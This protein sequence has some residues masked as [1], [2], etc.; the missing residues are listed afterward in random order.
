MKELVKKMVEHE[1]DGETSEDAAKA[2]LSVVLADI[3]ESPERYVK[4]CIECDG[5]GWFSKWT[6]HKGGEVTLEQ[7]QCEWC[8]GKGLVAVEQGRE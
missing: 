3:K 2:M 4:V 8:Y 1:Y 7:V 5:K 6:F